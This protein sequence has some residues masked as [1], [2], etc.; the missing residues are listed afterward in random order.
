[1]TLCKTAEMKNASH[2]VVFP[3]GLSAGPGAEVEPGR[4]GLQHAA[5][6][7]GG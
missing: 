1:M 6:R 2:C 7:H 5:M 3:A 4:P